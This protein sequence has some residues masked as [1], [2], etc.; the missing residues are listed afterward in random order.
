MKKKE[1]M[2]LETDLAIEH[3]ERKAL[4][5]YSVDSTVLTFLTAGLLKI[6]TH[7]RENTKDDKVK[8]RKPKNSKKRTNDRPTARNYRVAKR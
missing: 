4:G 7:I 5:G 8:A 3:D 2:S 6:V 1:L